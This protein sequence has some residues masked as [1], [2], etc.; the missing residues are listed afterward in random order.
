MKEQE[1]SGLGG[2]QGLVVLPVPCLGPFLSPG[3]AGL[4]LA[5]LP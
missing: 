5:L 3:R 4:V 2:Q 1:L